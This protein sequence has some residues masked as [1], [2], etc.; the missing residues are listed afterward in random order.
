MILVA[1][2]SFASS[3]SY[4]KAL[5]SGMFFSESQLSISWSFIPCL[6]TCKAASSFILCDGQLA[7]M[8]I[9]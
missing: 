3:V 8:N 7:A 1:L 4:T 2:V 5:T 9:G 6:W